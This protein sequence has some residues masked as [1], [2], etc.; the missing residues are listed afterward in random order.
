MAS[1]FSFRLFYNWMLICMVVGVLFIPPLKML[2]SPE[3]NW[4]ATEQRLLSVLP[5]LPESLVQLDDFFSH[6]DNYFKDHFGFRDKF[7]HRYQREMEK[8]FDKIGVNAPVLKGLDGW[9]FYTA[10]NLFKDFQGK[11]PLG[12]EQLEE[13]RRGQ[14]KK[15]DWL[16]QQGI[17]YIYAVAPEKQSIYPE[18][19]SDSAMA[20]K[21]MSRFDQLSAVLGQNPPPYFV[22]LHD[23][24]R[25]AKGT[26]NLYLKNDTHWNMLGGYVA[27][28]TLFKRISEIFPNTTLKTHFDFTDDIPGVPDKLGHPGDL[29]RMILKEEELRESFPKLKNFTPC[30]HPLSFPY[31]LSNL[32]QDA[33]KRSFATGCEQAELTAVVFRD[34]FTKDLQPFFSENFKKVIYLWK[35]YDQKNMEEIMTFFKPDIVLEITVERHMF[36][37]IAPRLQNDPGK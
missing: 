30:S 13:W 29:A 28:Q 16:R 2:V 6:L 4:S 19:L 14:E 26:K 12:Q 33:D 1:S 24:L 36:D 15:V 11:T 31:G 20:I 35:G 17:S 25:Q 3:E 21:G 34:S 32:V 10:F 5:E 23:A 37:S 8:R 27:F 7:I 22:N 9:Y 18:H